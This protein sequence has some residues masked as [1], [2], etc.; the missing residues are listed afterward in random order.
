[1]TIRMASYSIPLP[2]SQLPQRTPRKRKLKP[3]IENSQSPTLHDEPLLAISAHDIEYSAVVTPEERI[4]RRLAGQPLE[5][6]PPPFPFP[7][8]SVPSAS[9]TRPISRHK[10][11]PKT[12]SLRSQHLCAMTTLLHRCL[13]AKDY[14]RASRALGLILQTE[15]HGKFIDLRHAGLWGIGTEILLNIPD[16]RQGSSISRQGFEQAKVLYDRIAL[17]HPWHRTW[18]DVTNAQDF[19]PAMFGLW[20]YV[21]CLESKRLQG[22]SDEVGPENNRDSF[23]GELQAKRYELAEAERIGQEID[24]L[25]ST[26]PFVDDLELLRLRAHVG[27]WTADLLEKTDELGDEVESNT[28]MQEQQMEDAW[29]G[30]ANIDEPSQ[31]RQA[32]HKATI[33]R[34]LA[35]RTLAKLRG[36]DDGEQSDADGDFTSNNDVEN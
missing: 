19:K 3:A 23:V 31:R 5:E 4:Q 9:S 8:A 6:L 34:Q 35:N 11:E 17:Q 30:N 20:I 32:N 1:M 26:I 21:T 16:T 18:P 25:M 2:S 28:S 7:H 29:L 27:L 13:Q 22:G 33:A 15:T 12:V 24:T 14:K 10:S 36:N